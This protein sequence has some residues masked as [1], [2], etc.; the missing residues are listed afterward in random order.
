MSPTQPSSFEPD[1]ESAAPPQTTTPR[2]LH[3]G[4]QVGRYRLLEKLGGGVMAAVYRA[5]EEATGAP[6]AV[7]VLLPDADPVVSERFRQ[8]ART[9]GQL[10]H[11]NIVPILDEGHEPYSCLLYTSRCV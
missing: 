11:P 3:V 5:V 8:E 6:V 2:G 9:H 1:R 4:Y 7:K 10:R